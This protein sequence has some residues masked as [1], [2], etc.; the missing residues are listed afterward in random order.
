[1]QCT[2][3]TKEGTQCGF[4]AQNGLS[5]CFVHDPDKE[6]ERAEAR[7]RG[8]ES[9]KAPTLPVG[10]PEFD[11]KTA[12]D[13]RA[14]LEDTINKVRAGQLDAKIANNLGYLSSQLLKAI[15]ISD[16]EQRLDEIEKQAG[17]A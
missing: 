2:F 14:M 4:P 8:G 3:T 1:M 16:V 6:R 12:E 9:R 10:A 11:L 5:V 17:K 13:V 15:E 7:R